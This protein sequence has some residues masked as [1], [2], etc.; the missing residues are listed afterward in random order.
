MGSATGGAA[1]IGAD[2]AKVGVG[3]VTI[4]AD[5]GRGDTGTVK[6]GAGTGKAEGAPSVC[7][8]V[9]AVTMGWL[10]SGCGAGAGGS[11]TPTTG[12][13]LSPESFPPS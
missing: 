2:A 9:V 10:S 11:T 13:G 12:C 3:A 7:T 1:K 5:A 8:V 6:V 4:G